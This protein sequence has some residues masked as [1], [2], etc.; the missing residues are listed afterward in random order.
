MNDKINELMDQMNEVQ[1]GKPWIGSS[2]AKKINSV[3]DMDFFR[4]P[5]QDMHSVAEIISHL[6][7]WRIEVALKIDTGKGSLTD[8]DPSNWKNLKE[9]KSLGRS[10]ILQQY[11]ESLSRV[12]EL[13][14]D[15]DDAFLKRTYYDPDF[16]G[17]FT[18][19]WLLHGML[20][21]DVYHLGQI[22]YIVKFL[23]IQ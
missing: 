20:Q 16:K 23:K 17:E 5:M 15:K 21:H 8:D 13:L 11:N 6:T 12:F 10:K 19:A 9:L 14:S 3:A 7:T 22:G 18:Y 1:N 4:R 2:F